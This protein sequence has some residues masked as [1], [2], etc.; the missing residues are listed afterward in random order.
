MTTERDLANKFSR[1]GHITDV[2]L[3]Y[4]RQVSGRSIAELCCC[5]LN[6]VQGIG[7]LVSHQHL[8]HKPRFC[9]T[10][11]YLCCKKMCEACMLHSRVIVQVLRWPVEIATQEMHS[12]VCRTVDPAVSR[13]HLHC[14]K[15][16]EYVQGV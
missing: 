1:Y 13:T 9:Y 5:N 2:Q 6:A 7:Y 3:I 16:S 4:D 15:V 12:E 11:S 10:L 14:R 8:L